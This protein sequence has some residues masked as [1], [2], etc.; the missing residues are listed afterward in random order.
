MDVK[1]LLRNGSWVTV[2]YGITAFIGLITTVVFTRLAT[3]ETYGTFQF[4]VALAAFFSVFS[5]PGFN[6]A[7]LKSVV[8][9]EK[10]GVLQA[11]RL[12]FYASLVAIPCILLYGW[13]QMVFHA[14][15]LSYGLFIIAALA[16]PF[17]YAPN[18]WYAYYEGQ[19]NFFA[20]T[21]RTLLITLCTFGG[22]WMALWLQAD[23]AVL[24]SI[25]FGVTIIFSLW[26]IGEIAFELRKNTYLKSY[27]LDT[28]YGL[29]VTVQKFVY[30]LSETLP[31][32]VI[33]SL[34]GYQELALFQIAFFLFSS[35]S[36]YM[37]ALIALYLPHLFAGISPKG[38]KVLL[39]NFISGVIT[40]SLLAVFLFFIFPLLYDQTYALSRTLSW[41]LLP[42]ALLLP[43]KNYLLSYFTTQSKN[44]PLIIIYAGANLLAFFGVWIL[45]S[46]GVLVAGAAYLSLLTGAVTVPLVIMYFRKNNQ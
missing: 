36:G 13:Y 7:A 38:K 29:A 39:Y 12:S 8:A 17:F 34:F 20:V 43:L 30:S 18:T 32:L 4:L 45:Q 46:S 9:G 42:I 10:K 26:F 33:G 22:I 15:P 40:M 27:P 28:R 41:Y 21:W 3:P 5:L 35:L 19:K 2:R 23:V 44:A 16:F 1:Y 6:M 37:G 11:V 31:I 14:H 25:Y 24:L